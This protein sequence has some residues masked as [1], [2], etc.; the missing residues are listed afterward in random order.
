MDF[1]FLL[2]E[3][4]AFD[5]VHLEARWTK[6][7]KAFGIP[8][9][10]IKTIMMLYKDTK[11]IVRSLDND[12]DPFEAYSKVIYL[13]HFSSYYVCLDYVLQTSLNI[14][15]EIGFKIKNL[16]SE[17]ILQCTLLMLTTL[18]VLGQL[19]QAERLLHL[20]EI[21]AVNIDIIPPPRNLWGQNYFTKWPLLGAYHFFVYQGA[22]LEMRQYY[23]LTKIIGFYIPRGDFSGVTF[24]FCLLF[25]INCHILFILLFVCLSVMVQ[26]NPVCS[27]FQLFAVI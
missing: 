3:Y 14:H 19:F 17:D 21:S 11:A 13:S 5:S 15:N 9:Q 23:Q 25:I 27:V 1:R 26:L 20:L 2:S 22:I 24:I 4:L 18:I 12:T 10:I 8:N 6:F 16:G 7:S